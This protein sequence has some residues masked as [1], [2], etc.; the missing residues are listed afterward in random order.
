MCASQMS[1]E[2]IAGRLQAHADVKAADDPSP[3]PRSR[4]KYRTRQGARHN[5][6]IV[7]DGD[8][9]QRIVG[10]VSS[11]SHSA[12]AREEYPQAWLWTDT[13]TS[14]DGP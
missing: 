11:I 7:P 1:S 6:A 13:R 12:N 8:E 14:E 5:C 3:P 10:V 2:Q 9:R 4:S